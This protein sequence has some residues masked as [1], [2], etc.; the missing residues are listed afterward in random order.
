MSL[1]IAVV[2]RNCENIVQFD[3]QSIPG[4]YKEYAITSINKR[5]HHILICP[6]GYKYGM[7]VSSYKGTWWR[8]NTG[9]RHQNGKTK[10]CQIRIRTRM[11]D[12]YEMIE[13]VKRHCHV[14]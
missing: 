1:F 10:R 5:G 14:P 13:K 8:C 11:I 9:T 7:H 6:L 2:R 3:V 12:G 4:E